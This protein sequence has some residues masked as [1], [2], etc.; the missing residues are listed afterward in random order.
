M[1]R[2]PDS[3]LEIMLIIWEYNR[4]VTRF[5]IEDK[6]D[7]DRKLSP[8]TILSFLARLQKRGFLEVTKVGKNNLYVPIIDKDS[9]MKVESKNILT[10]LYRNSAKNF[11]A[12]LYDGDNL[13]ADDIAELEEYIAQMKKG[14]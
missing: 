10:K 5:E 11:I 12:A 13:S 6:L 14:Q 3:E 2:L 7:E 8:T 4:P 1:K 9:Y